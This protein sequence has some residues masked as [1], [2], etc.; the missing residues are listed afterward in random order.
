MKITG[1]KLA[2][3]LS[4]LGKLITRTSSVELHQAVLLEARD[5][6][7]RL[8]TVAQDESLTVTIPAEG[9]AGFRHVVHYAKL[10]ELTRNPA[11]TVTFM[12]LNDGFAAQLECRRKIVTHALPVLNIDWPEAEAAP[13]EAETASLPENFTALLS[14]AAPL[15]NRNEAR[16]QLRGIH[17]CPEGIV[18]TD[19]KQLLH[20]PLD[21]T[22][23]SLVTLPFPLAL[24]TAKP[25]VPGTLTLWKLKDVQLFKIE[26]GNFV[27]AGK[28]VSGSYPEWRKVI[29]E[30]SGLNYAIAFTPEQA[31]Q[32]TGFLKTVPD[33]EPFHAIELNVVPG[34]VTVIPNNFPDMELR[35]EATVIGAQPRAVLALNKYILL[36]MLQQGYTKFR[37]HSDGRIPVI[38]EGGS[39]RYLA[40][41]IHILPKDQPEK[42]KTKMENIKRIE[43]TETA[44]EETV[45]S[46]NPMEE[47]NHSIE[48]L[49]GK[50]RTLLDESALLAR[51]VKEAVLQQKQREREFV[52]AKR[53]IER[54]RMAI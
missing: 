32:L 20:L 38:A 18:V 25:E 6:Q 26:A 30:A 48:D 22:L 28:A 4:A 29:P 7:L 45:E 35:L 42:E 49:R 46:V 5:G 27:W 12:E 47:L 44:I 24:L 51:K 50:L 17:L 10:R 16:H 41:P 8:R 34:G 15:V 36:R 33:H 53:A 43:H 19:G 21:W 39:G 23:K 52:Q 37:A 3:A 1:K 14:E 11:G 31:A 54:I 9:A 40:M 13:A 2:E